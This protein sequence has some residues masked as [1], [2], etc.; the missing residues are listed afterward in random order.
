MGP[1]RRHRVGAGAHAE[2]GPR[3]PGVGRKAT[4]MQL[5]ILEERALLARVGMGLGLGLGLGLGQ[6]AALSLALSPM[7]IPN[8]IP[9]LR[10]E[11]VPRLALGGGEARPH[12]RR[13]EE[14]H[15][16]ALLSE[17]QPS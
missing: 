7:P 9:L 6:G 2:R 17:Q 10:G 12:Y 11:S 5:S 15:T 8:P 1:Q 4:A 14:A 3:L 16:L 13:V